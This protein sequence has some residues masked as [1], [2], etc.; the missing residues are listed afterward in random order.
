MIRIIFTLNN[1]YYTYIQCINFDVTLMDLLS[2]L[3]FSIFCSLAHSRPA[4]LA[5]SLVLALFKRERARSFF[6]V[7]FC[8]AVLLFFFCQSFFRFISAFLFV[9]V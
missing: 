4:V 6:A 1:T 2:L 8:V 3:F 7:F 5:H 9:L